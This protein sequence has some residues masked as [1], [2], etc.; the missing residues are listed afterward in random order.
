M[1]SYKDIIDN[2]LWCDFRDEDGEKAG[3]IDIDV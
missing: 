3:K 2:Q 1:V